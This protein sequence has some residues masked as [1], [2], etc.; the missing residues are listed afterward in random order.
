MRV[1]VRKIYGRCPQMRCIYF[2]QLYV[3]ELIY[4]RWRNRVTD[5]PG[6]K[7]GLVLQGAERRRDFLQ[8]PAAGRL[9]I[10][11]PQA[12]AAILSLPSLPLLRRRQTSI[13][14]ERRG[15]KDFKTLLIL[16]AQLII[17]SIADI[18]ILSHWCLKKKASQ[19]STIG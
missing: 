12:L 9:N 19:H 17:T 5:F 2:S 14:N 6:H 3:V 16:K 11:T 7:R 18:A 8:V 10:D 13:L 15:R 1:N 4:S